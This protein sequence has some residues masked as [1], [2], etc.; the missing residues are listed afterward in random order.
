MTYL[1]YLILFAALAHPPTPIHQLDAQDWCEEQTN[2]VESGEATFCEV[3][4]LTFT[5]AS[6]L[7]IDAAPNGSIQAEGE[8]RSDIR[9]QARV[10]TRSQSEERARELAEGVTIRT[11]GTLRYELAPELRPRRQSGDRRED[12]VSV[13]FRLRVPHAQDMEL[14]TMNGGIELEDVYGRIRFESLNGTVHLDGLGGDVQGHT[15]N[16]GLHVQL[17][18]SEWTGNGLD[19][20]STNGR[21]DL[22]VPRDYSAELAAS[23]VNGRFDADLHHQEHSSGRRSR[24]RQLETTLGDGGAPV[25]VRT[26]NGRVQIDAQ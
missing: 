25:R 3:R 8:T 21:V 16:G 10:W 5:P 6:A 19:V 4:T 17:T 18:G 13:S 26:T 23:T 12:Y 24:N 11:D 1:P 22:D 9:V 15:I 14:Q 20:S 2:Y 7:R